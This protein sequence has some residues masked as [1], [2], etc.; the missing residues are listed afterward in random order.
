MIAD[1]AGGKIAIACQ[2]LLTLT[3]RVLRRYDPASD[4][5]DDCLI[6]FAG[7]QVILLLHCDACCTAQGDVG[8]KAQRPRGLCDRTRKS[9][10]RN[11]YQQELLM[12]LFFFLG[13]LAIIGLIIT[14]AITLQ[15]GDDNKITIQIDKTKVKE[16]ARTVIEKGKEVIEG[17]R[18]ASRERQTN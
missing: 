17:V 3:A 12:R 10:F 1:R 15:R 7:Q 5:K 14:G 18:E 16:E 2:R 11:G 4:V 8:C 13:S 9:S 6:V